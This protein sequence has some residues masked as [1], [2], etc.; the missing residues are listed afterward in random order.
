M[1][2]FRLRF[3]FNQQS[4]AST[5]GLGGTRGGDNFSR[6]IVEDVAFSYSEGLFKKLKADI[7]GR[8]HGDVDK[9]LAHM[10]RMFMS[11][12]V[13]IAGRNRGATGILTAKSP[14][15]D[16]FNES[17]YV[18][19]RSVAGTWPR[20]SPDYLKWRKRREDGGD[21]SWFHRKGNVLA[22]LASAKTW[23]SAYGGITV[24]VK[25]H[26][27][28]GPSDPAARGFN[29]RLGG[30]R[31]GN[32]RVGVATIRVDAM[33]GITPA[34]LPATGGGALGDFGANPRSNGLLDKLGDDIAYRLGGDPLRVPFRP[35]VQPFL[36]F[37]LTRQLPNA[38]FKR[39]EQGLDGKLLNDNTGSAGRA[40][41]G[42][43]SERSLSL[44]DYSPRR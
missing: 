18:P 26:T 11:G 12:V 6:V 24:T 1:S 5:K 29:T 42:R 21:P 16:M 14:K 15:A 22:K 43:Y 32:A 23:T 34:M 25:R 9:E 19:V 2:S 35:T 7:G 13:G 33:G 4:K 41:K 10:A 44:K 3:R 36:A 39:I 28:F 17:L 31:G 37:F 30:T 8:I 38:V 27:S 20:R 40:S